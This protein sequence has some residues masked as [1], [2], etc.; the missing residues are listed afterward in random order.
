[1][2]Q[3]SL[4][5]TFVNWSIFPK[6]L[7]TK[8]T[9]VLLQLKLCCFYSHSLFLRINSLFSLANQIIAYDHRANFTDRGVW[10][11]VQHSLAIRKIFYHCHPE[12]YF[13]GCIYIKSMSKCVFLVFVYICVFYVHFLIFQVKILCTYERF[14]LYFYHLNFHS[15][16]FYGLSLKLK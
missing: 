5:T 7:R 4:G 10:K 3:I 14:A 16:Y 8:P 2:S 15:L 6:L 13:L 11:Q 12:G 1:M 9:Q